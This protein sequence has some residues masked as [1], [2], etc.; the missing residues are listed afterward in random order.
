MSTA[1]LNDWFGLMC[2]YAAAETGV[3]QAVADMVKQKL[4]APFIL[5]KLADAGFGDAIK[6]A[7][8]RGYSDQEIVQRFGGKAAQDV[9]QAQADVAKQG[10]G[11]NVV[12]GVGNAV[13]DAAL[14][15]KQMLSTDDGDGEVAWRRHRGDGPRAVRSGALV[16]MN[17]R[18]FVQDETGAYSS[19]RLIALTVCFAAV[20]IC[21]WLSY[22]DLMSEGYFAALLA[23]GAGTHTLNKFLDTRVAPKEA[24]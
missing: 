12:Q 18:Q 2:A 3:E 20:V 13:S 7:Q 22:R 23:Y 8:Q 17:W 1:T 19:A 9:E 14:G 6:T 16:Q 5:T 15:A 21:G 4:G 24:K 10:F 11:T